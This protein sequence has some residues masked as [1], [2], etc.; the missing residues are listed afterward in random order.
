MVVVASAVL[1]AALNPM[2]GW[3][4]LTYHLT[5]PAIYLEHGGF[6]RIPFNVYSNWPLSMELLYGLGLALQDHVGA[7]LLHWGVLILLLVALFRF[8]ARRHA[9]WVGV[10]ACAFL[11]ANPVVIHEAGIAYV[12]LA[13]GFFLLMGLSLLTEYSEAGGRHSLRLAGLCF[14]CLATTKISGVL[15]LASGWTFLGASSY[16]SSSPARLITWL[17]TSAVLA[18]PAAVMLTPW[19]IKAYMHTGNPIYPFFWN[20]FGGPE[21]SDSLATR[22]AEWQASIGMGRRWLDYLVLA[23]RVILLGGD[24]YGRFEGTLSWLWIAGLPLIAIVRNRESRVLGLCAGVYFIVWAS[25]SQQARFLVPVLPLLSAALAIT[26]ASIPGRTPLGSRAPLASTASF[27]P[28]R[29][30]LVIGVMLSST[31]PL[32]GEALAVTGSVLRSPPDLTRWVP[33]PSYAY[34]ARSLPPDAK[35]LLM[36]T[37]HGM[38]IKRSY[39]ADSF[40]EASQIADTFGSARTLDDVDG[41]MAALGITH[42]LRDPIERASLPGLLRAYARDAARCVPL[43]GNTGMFAVCAVTYGRSSR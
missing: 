27:R 8:C 31:Y 1:L 15:F 25:S 16:R 33:D 30:L 22:F 23:P 41:E 38:F 21:W 43:P 12:E 5:I 39:I 3:D 10:M 9:P 13:L 19:L 40:F 7:R 17:R 26:M 14:G 6:V 4:D 29:F 28:L 11:L 35:L 37:N 20:V 24:G 18:L 34:V 32:F 36:D 42:I 2:P